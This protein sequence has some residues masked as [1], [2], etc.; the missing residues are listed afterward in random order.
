MRSNTIRVAT[1]HTKPITLPVL[2]D[3]HGAVI[4]LTGATVTLYM[5]DSRFWLGEDFDIPHTIAYTS[6]IAGHD[7][8]IKI[9]GGTVA[10][11]GSHPDWVLTY[12]PDSDDFDTPGTYVWQCRI[13][14]DSVDMYSPL[15]GQGSEDP[16]SI[17]RVT[18]GLKRLADA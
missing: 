10:V 7:A 3:D 8:T 18:P 1:G 5:M 6:S 16:P 12:T 15:L 11:T 9:N 4:D 13:V 2:R 14:D 17:I